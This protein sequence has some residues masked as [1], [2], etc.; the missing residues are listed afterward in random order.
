MDTH[1]LQGTSK[2]IPWLSDL[3]ESSEGSLEVLPV[4]CLCEFLLMGSRDSIKKDESKDKSS[5]VS[6][7]YC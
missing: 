4:Q 5:Q 1:F 3:V 7:C 2:A 6:A